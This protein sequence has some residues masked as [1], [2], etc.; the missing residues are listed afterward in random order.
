MRCLTRSYRAAFPYTVA[1][2]DAF[3]TSLQ[4]DDAL[5]QA[6][7]LSVRLEAAVLYRRERKCLIKAAADIV[8]LYAAA[9]A[10]VAAKASA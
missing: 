6:G 5:L 1:E 2:L 7:N 8:S 9:T 3:P 4:E 10:R